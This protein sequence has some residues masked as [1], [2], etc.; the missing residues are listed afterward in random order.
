M[1]HSSL[2]TQQSNSL[3]RCK[4]VSLRVILQENYVSYS[5][6]LEMNGL[7]RL[8][9]RWLARCLYFSV[10]FTKDTSNSRF[11]QGIKI[12]EITLTPEQVNSSRSTLAG[13]NNTKK[14]PSH[15]AQWALASDGRGQ[16]GR[17]AGQGEGGQEGGGQG[18]IVWTN[19]G[20]L[21]ELWQAY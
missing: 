8:S 16:E 13:P 17:M 19:I 20:H 1:F 15:F 10:K 14:G 9:D 7:D 4:A 2:K 3:E 18:R 21:Y 11:F 6:A 5:A 12:W